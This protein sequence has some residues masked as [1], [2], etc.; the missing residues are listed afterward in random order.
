MA[1]KLSAYL[2]FL[3]DLL[4]FF[5]GIF[6]W[7]LKH[8][9]VWIFLSS[10]I[11][12]KN[13]D[14]LKGKLVLITGAAHGLGRELAIDLAKLGCRIAVVDI[15]EVGAKKVA[16]E[17]DEKEKIAKSFKADIADKISIEKLKNDV[18]KQMGKVDILICNA[19]LMPDLA[20]DE[21]EHLFMKKMID[22]NVYGT[23]LVINNTFWTNSRQHL[24]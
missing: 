17:I 14:K 13:R 19:G 21:L 22:V 18:T 11:V 23:F 8:L 20:D 1:R 12:A 4:M 9:F 5:I 2:E 10:S 3:I 7:S 15:D 16:L 24:L 6:L